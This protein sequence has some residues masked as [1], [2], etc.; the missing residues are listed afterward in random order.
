MERAKD[1]LKCNIYFCM[2]RI[3]SSNFLSDLVVRFTTVI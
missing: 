3:Q 2:R 1:A